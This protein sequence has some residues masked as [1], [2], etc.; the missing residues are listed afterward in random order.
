[1]TDRGRGDG[2]EFESLKQILLD[3][4]H[5]R[6]LPALLS[7]LA[8][9]LRNL[10]EVALARIWLIR[11]GD[12]CATCPARP[13]C[14]DQTR[15]LHLVA[16]AARQI[17]PDSGTDWF[18]MDGSAAR[19]ADLSGCTLYTNVEPCVLCSYAI[20]K[21]RIDRVVIGIPAGALG[22]LSSSYPILRDADISSFG[23]PP[24]ITQGVLASECGEAIS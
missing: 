24:A 3:M 22:G 23:A 9:R 2:S 1:M 4:A 16:S 5:E 6:S 7:L 15:C 8:E 12:L 14:P 10:R 18:R 21:S 20:R 19:S 11:P 13:E 17:N